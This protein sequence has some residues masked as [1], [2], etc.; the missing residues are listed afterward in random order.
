MPGA[1][2]GT[3]IDLPGFDGAWHGPALAIANTD[4]AFT[5][6]FTPR[7]A[8]RTVTST[9]DDGHA[10]VVLRYGSAA[11]FAASCRALTSRPG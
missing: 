1:G 8:A 7:G 10:S 4:D 9:A 6:A 5:Q 2:Q 3:R 11:G